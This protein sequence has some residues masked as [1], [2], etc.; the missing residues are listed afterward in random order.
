MLDLQ[1]TGV[2]LDNCSC[3]VDTRNEAAPVLAQRA[4]TTLAGFLAETALQQT[5]A[6]VILDD[7]VNSFDYRRLP[8]PRSL[9]SRNT[10]RR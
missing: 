6:L 5:V 4:F 1:A 9:Q 7:S 8:S 10:Q 2:P 3:L